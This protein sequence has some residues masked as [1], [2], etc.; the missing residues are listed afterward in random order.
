MKEPEKEDISK[1]VVLP[2]GRHWAAL[3]CNDGSVVLQHLSDVFIGGKVE[4]VDLLNK[5]K[6]F[7][8]LRYF[9]EEMD[10]ERIAVRTLL[11][12]PDGSVL[13][14]PDAISPSGVLSEDYYEIIPSSAFSAHRYFSRKSGKNDW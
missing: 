3:L 8:S 10:Q 1:G 14:D 12:K 13:V 6:S 4:S 11:L 2:V 5:N 7:D 9:L